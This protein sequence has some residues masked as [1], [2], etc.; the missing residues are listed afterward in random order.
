MKLN[1]SL[2]QTKPGYFRIENIDLSII[3]VLPNN[4]K[5]M[6]HQVIYLND[7]FEQVIS[8]AEELIDSKWQLWLWMHQLPHIVYL[9]FRIPGEVIWQIQNNA[10]TISCSHQATQMYWT[11]QVIRH[12]NIPLNRFVNAINKT[13]SL[14]SSYFVNN[15]LPYYKLS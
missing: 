13:N 11:L 15:H 12:L 6:I 4:T 8:D 9:E 14:Q 2:T 10:L 7:E 1:S 5:I 3:D